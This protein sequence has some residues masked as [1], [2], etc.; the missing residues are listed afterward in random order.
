MF[1]AAKSILAETAHRPWSLPQRPWVMAQSWQRLLFAH[2]RVA[3][4]TLRPLIPAHLEI[5]TFAGEAWVGVVPFSMREVHARGTFNLPGLSAFPELN[6]RTYVKHEGKPGVWFFSLDADNRAAVWGARRFFHLP[7]FGAS[8][9]SRSEGEWVHYCSRRTDARSAHADF[10]A[11]Y[12]PTS[13]VFRAER[14]SLDAW[15]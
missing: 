6:V 2:W 9:T 8:M 11:S 13:P 14:S 1:P 15:L 12:R 10:E 7:Y 4:A 3:L 5:D